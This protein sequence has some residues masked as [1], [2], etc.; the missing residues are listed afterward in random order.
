V[1]L[2]TPTSAEL[3][4]LCNTLLLV[5]DGHVAP[6][7]LPSI[8]A[9]L[10]RPEWASELS[11]RGSGSVLHCILQADGVLPTRSLAEWIVSQQRFDTLT[12]FLAEA[13]G[14][15]GA[16][17]LERSGWFSCRYTLR[18]AAS[19]GGVVSL[20]WMFERME[21]GKERAGISEYSLGQTNV[22]AIFN[23]FAALQHNPEVRARDSTRAI[24]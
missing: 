22:E 11:E 21:G 6:P 20:A 2:R 1:K 15:N 14:E 5:P 23:R 19:G 4:S 13:F 7:Q 17:L 3:A 8:F 9:A 18:P 24:N 12:R 10:G 16:Q